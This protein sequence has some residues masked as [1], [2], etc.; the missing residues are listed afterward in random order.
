[1]GKETALLII[2][3]QNAMF[4]E[5]SPVYRGK[6]LLENLKTLI[7]KAKRAGSPVIYVRH[8]D[9]YLSHGSLGW[10]VHPAIAPEAGDVI[11]DKATPDSFNKTN[12]EEVLKEKGVKNLVIAGIQSEMCVDT[13]TRRAFSLDYDITLVT[14]AHSTWNSEELTA[15]QIIDHHN[16]TLRWFSDPKKTAEIV[17]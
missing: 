9:D 16:S 13:T 7:S 1:M 12:L 15:Q 5:E 4:D 8:N 2:D 6:E 11:I 10:D 17:F 3:V 14:D